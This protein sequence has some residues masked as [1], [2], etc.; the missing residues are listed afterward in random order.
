MQ[1]IGVVASGEIAVGLVEGHELAGEL[2]IYPPRDDADAWQS[3]GIHS[4]PMESIVDS[5]AEI[6]E[7]LCREHGAKPAV[8]GVGFPGII[9]NGIIEESPNLQQAKGARVAQTLGEA[10]AARGLPI[11]VSLFNDADVMAAGLAATRGQLEKLIRVWTLGHGIGFGRY[12]HSDEP[13]EGGHTVV[14][15]DPKEAYCGCGGKGHLEGI[16]GNRA[17][18]LR[19]LDLEPEEIFANA[20]QAGAAKKDPRCAEFEIKWHRALAAASATSIHM[21]GP[22]KFFISGNN[23]RFIKVSL[24]SQYLHEMVTMTPLQGSIFE[25]VPTSTEIAVVGAGVNASRALRA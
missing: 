13:W 2:R 23:A 8:A 25:V 11:A 3:G 10:L 5:I 14:T 17:M 22:G 19:F 20:G 15:L 18:R 4:M 6:I 16:M 9:R 24:L 12:P 7:D 21:E 1:T